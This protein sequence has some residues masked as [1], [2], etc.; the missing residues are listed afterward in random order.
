MSNI[1]TRLLRGFRNICLLRLRFVLCM[2]DGPGNR[3]APLQS[4]HD[5]I[6]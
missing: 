4:G 5:Y 2:P 6:L 3:A 1:V